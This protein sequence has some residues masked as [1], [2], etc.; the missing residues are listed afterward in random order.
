MKKLNAI[1]LAC[2]VLFINELWAQAT[3]T[4]YPDKDAMI[5][6]ITATT[7]YG[8]ETGFG[9]ARMTNTGV[10]YTARGLIEF[11]LSSI[12][13][14]SVINSATLYLYG[15][16]HHYT[17]KSTASY[18]ERISQSWTESTVTWQNQP[19]RS[20]THAK[21]SLAAVSSSTEDEIVESTDLKSHVQEM[22]DDV[23]TNNGFMFVLQSE[24]DPYA[25]LRYA[26]SDYGTPS[27]RPKLVIEYTA[28][29]RFV[30]LLPELDGA[31]YNAYDGKIY[32]KYEEEYQAGNLE[33]YVYDDFHQLVFDHTTVAKT[34]VYGTNWLFW[35]LNLVTEMVTSKYYTMEVVDENGRKEYLRF[36]MTGADND[37]VSNSV[38][39][40]IDHLLSQP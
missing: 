20:A 6:D 35:N 31:Y 32:L 16:N 13:E 37:G 1:F 36:Y 26:S 30:S 8:T 9:C 38:S 10:P 15:V 11:D 40:G 39:S 12:P 2:S 22:L 3:A 23:S 18:F 27:K 14:G 24:V 17:D 19:S 29:E 28:P 33:Y 7:N 21:I 4:L 34:K 5:V 25:R